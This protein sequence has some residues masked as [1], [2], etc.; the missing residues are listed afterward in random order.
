MFHPHTNEV[1]DSMIGNGPA[2]GNEELWVHNVTCDNWTLTI[3]DI[4]L[5]EATVT[6]QMNLSEQKQALNK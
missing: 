6:T 5:E 4:D 2:I 3:N 1:F